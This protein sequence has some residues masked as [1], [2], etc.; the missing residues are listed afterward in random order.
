M[1]KSKTIKK[2]D[3]PNVEAKPTSSKTPVRKKNANSK[4]KKH[5][6]RI[7]ILTP[8]GLQVNPRSPLP[9]MPT[10]HPMNGPECENLKQWKGQVKNPEWQTGSTITTKNRPHAPHPSRTSIIDKKS[11]LPAPVQT[12][13]SNPGQN[14]FLQL[15][16][17]LRNKI[18]D[19]VYP[20]R[21][22][23]IERLSGKLN[24]TCS[25]AI[26]QTWIPHISRSLKEKQVMLSR[27]AWRKQILKQ[28]KSQNPLKPVSTTTALLQSCRSLYIE[29]CPYFY[30][31]HTFAFNRFGV[32]DS[33]M[34]NLTPTSTACIYAVILFHES[35]GD[36][37][38]TKDTQWKEVHSNAFFK[39]C[40]KAAKELSNLNTMSL[41]VQINDTPLQLSLDASWAKPLLAFGGLHLSKVDVT[42]MLRGR[43]GTDNILLQ[44]FAAILRKALLGRQAAEATMCTHEAI[45]KLPEVPKANILV[46]RLNNAPI[47]ISRLDIGTS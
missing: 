16:G 44:D 29:L 47:D 1:A 7:G 2:Q 3:G 25:Y 45:R 40:Q 43:S 22:Y 31:R 18:W 30:S 4:S 37:H 9:L 19:L 5:L 42:L 12:R 6:Q 41:R 21:V 27:L 33:F 35:Y 39:F 20:Q 10:H 24:L 28:R 15:P 17:E 26:G 23:R 11:V 32:F 14:L 34:R 13:F 38:W 46:L 8:N 36:P